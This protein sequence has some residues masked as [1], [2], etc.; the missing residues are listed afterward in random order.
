MYIAYACIPFKS[1]IYIAR[2]PYAYSFRSR[3]LWFTISN[4]LF[5]STI[6]HLETSVILRTDV[7]GECMLTELMLSSE[8]DVI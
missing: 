1:I 5:M 3:I 2:I 4:T 8:T 6:I 7:V